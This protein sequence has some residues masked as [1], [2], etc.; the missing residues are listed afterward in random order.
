MGV[1]EKRE[2]FVFPKLRNCVPLFRKN[3]IP[4]RLYIHILN[5]AVPAMLF[6]LQRVVFSCKFRLVPIG[7][8][9]VRR[10]F[11]QNGR[12]RRNGVSKLFQTIA[13]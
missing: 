4:H 12:I 10:G 5:V 6:S 7:V 13:G 9:S 11:L 1:R 3:G 2:I 8:V